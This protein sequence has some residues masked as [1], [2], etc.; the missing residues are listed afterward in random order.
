MSYILYFIKLCTLA[1]NA[2]VILMF[3]LSQTGK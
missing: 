3:C 1:V 2:T